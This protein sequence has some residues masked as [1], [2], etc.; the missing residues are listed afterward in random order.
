MLSFFDVIFGISGFAFRACKKK[1]AYVY[2]FSIIVY[3]DVWGSSD[4]LCLLMRVRMWAFRDLSFFVFIF[5]ICFESEIS[6]FLSG[7]LGHRPFHHCIRYWHDFLAYLIWADYHSFSYSVLHHHHPHFH[8]WF[9]VFIPHFSF[10]LQWPIFG[11]DI[12]FTS[13]LYISLLVW[14]I[15]FVSS[16]TPRSH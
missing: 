16:S 2:L 7:A 10:F 8:S 12:L 9:I 14:S 11:F 6:D 3:V 1:N 15:S 13:P 4:W 5:V